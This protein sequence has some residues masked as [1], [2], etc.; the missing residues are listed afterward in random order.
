MIFSVPAAEIILRT[1][2]ERRAG[3]IGYEKTAFVVEYPE[4]RY[5]GRYD[6]GDGD[7]GLIEHIRQF[8]EICKLE[9]DRN[10]IAALVDILRA[11]MPQDAT[12]EAE[13][14]AEA[15]EPAEEPAQE[16]PSQ[17]SEPVLFLRS[18]ETENQ[19]FDL[20]AVPRGNGVTYSYTVNEYFPS[21][22]KWR[23]LCQENNLSGD[24]LLCQFGFNSF[25]EL[26]KA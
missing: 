2:D 8:G 19:R 13:E 6:L 22:H 17:L 3:V 10:R 7:G 16:K 12:G 26:M 14:T 11:Q 18:I 23:Y 4:G 15:E 25:A 21:L 9:E 1:L 20:F 24:A 5:E